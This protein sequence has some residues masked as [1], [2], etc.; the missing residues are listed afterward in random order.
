MSNPPA[1]PPQIPKHVS[2]PTQWLCCNCP[3]T[4]RTVT[5]RR[6][7]S[8][9]ITI[10]PQPTISSPSKSSSQ[11]SKSTQYLSSQQCPKCAHTLCPTC[12][13]DPAICGR[14]LVEELES[15]LFVNRMVR[16]ADAL[17]EGW[18]LDSDEEGEIREE[19]G[20]GRRRDELPCL[21]QQQPGM[22]RRFGKIGD[23]WLN[24]GGDKKG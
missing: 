24:P 10:P 22:R 21:F 12:T 19:S 20:E 13:T 11:P 8:T 9:Q 2:Q 16:L 15:K 6:Q 17:E 18:G 7:K 3:R 23:E 5:N 1:K 4:A 14:H